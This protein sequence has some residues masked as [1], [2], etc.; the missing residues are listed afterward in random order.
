MDE[1]KFCTGCGHAVEPDMQFCPQCG[2]VISGSAAE[3]SLKDQEKEINSL[4]LMARRNWL[5]FLLAIYAIPVIIISAIALFEASSM[6]SAIWASDEFRDWM[7]SH[8]FDFTQQNIQNY[9]TYAAGLGLG[10]GISAMISLICVYMRK[11]WII[12]VITCLA[13]TIL[14]FWSII[15][16]IIGF[17]VTWMIIGSRDIF[18]DSTDNTGNAG[19]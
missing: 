8:G 11:M 13:A 9:L 14:C 17:L 6:A 2:K 19:S 18:E 3:A 1:S 4:V 10:S 16:I 5:I 15:G 7:Q 12:A